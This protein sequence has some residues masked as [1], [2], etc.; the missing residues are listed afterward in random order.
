MRHISHTNCRCYMSCTMYL[1]V[2]VFAVLALSLSLSYAL[3]LLFSLL[4]YT[5][6][7][8]IFLYISD[9]LKCIWI[10]SESASTRESIY[11]CC[12]VFISRKDPDRANI[13][14]QPIDELRLL[15]DIAIKGSDLAA[16]QGYNT[17][18][19]SMQSLSF[20]LYSLL[21]QRRRRRP[22]FQATTNLQPSSK[23]VAAQ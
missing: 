4:L 7:G 9:S 20:W 6:R 1:F 10:Y 13:S 21:R 19:M 22:T 3:S 2:W 18:G 23:I 11:P 8:Y 12:T 5:C 15:Q 17:F 16:L 14:I